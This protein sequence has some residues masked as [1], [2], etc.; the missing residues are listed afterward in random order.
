MH[1]LCRKK[2][3]E[4]LRIEADHHFLADHQRWRGPAVIGADQLKDELLVGRD[5]TFFV[6]DTSILEVG[7]NRAA[8]RSARLR[9]DD[10][11]GGH[12]MNG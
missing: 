8:G 6:V 10:D 12:A 1:P 7:L 2:L 4:P 9:E 11:F 3:V 5:V